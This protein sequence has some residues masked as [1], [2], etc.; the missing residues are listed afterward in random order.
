MKK[1]KPPKLDYDA[2]LTENYLQYWAINPIGGS[3]LSI[4]IQG[5]LRSMAREILQNRGIA[6]VEK[7]NE[8]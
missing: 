5:M 6:I 8:S 3:G 4:R 7:T 1:Q 2:P